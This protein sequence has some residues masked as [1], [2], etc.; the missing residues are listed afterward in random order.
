[1]KRSPEAGRNI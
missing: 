1:M